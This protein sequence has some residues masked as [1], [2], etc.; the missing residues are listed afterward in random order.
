MWLSDDDV[1]RTVPLNEAMAAV[2]EIVVRETTGAARAIPKT[3]ATWDPSSAAHALGG[4]DAEAQLVGFKTWVNT[5]AG[6]AALFSLFRADNGALLATMQAVALGLIR[7]ASIS[8]IATQL[9]SDPSATELAIVGSGRQALLQVAAV[10]AVRPITRV[11]VWSPREE[12]R[13]RF[14]GTVKSELGLEAITHR[15][16]DEAVDG[17]QIVTLITRAREPFLPTGVLSAGAHLN[18]VGAILPQN[19]EF[20]AS[21]LE[22]ADLTVVDSLENARNSSRELRAFFGDDWSRVRT[23]GELLTGAAKRPESPRLTVFKGVGLGLGDLAVA[24]TAYRARANS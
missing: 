6:A 12:S 18:A 23:L 14:A 22:Q 11:R 19:A 5:P 21:L 4:F 10:R 2:A 24:A 9:L 7:T 20:D 13:E 1:T 17:A 15:S 3:M 8:G 16:V